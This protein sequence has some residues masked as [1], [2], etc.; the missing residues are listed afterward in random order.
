MHISKEEIQAKAEKLKNLVSLKNK[1]EDELLQIAE[2]IL[3]KGKSSMDI[4][5]LFS[6]RAESKR[7][8]ELLYKYL[9]DFTL[10]TVSDKN[11]LK[12]LIYLEILQQRLQE[13]LND[14]CK[15]SKK[16]VP[17]QLVETIHKNSDAILK[18]K[19]TL[20]LV[21]SKDKKESGLNVIET[22]MARFAQWRKN[23][24]ATRNLSCPHCGKMIMLKI[25]TEHWESQKHPYFRDRLLGNETLVRL[26]QAQRLTKKEVTDILESSTDYID[27]LINK[28]NMAPEMAE[29]T[30]SDVV[31]ESD[32]E[33][34]NLE[35]DVESGTIEAPSS[36][37]PEEE[38]KEHGSEENKGSRSADRKGAGGE[39]RR[40][41]SSESEGDSE[42]D[43]KSD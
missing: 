13:T 5:A 6:D 41:T 39:E 34:G 4:S 38:E 22:L 3:I 14:S 30:K 21:R 28:W 40:E 24:Q 2:D 16:G 7:A 33:S 10:S 23:N 26:Y 35:S 9:E 37:K 31:S 19:N 12:E 18:L 32:V 25:R 36:P 42:K 20:G 43:V 27:W 15:D 17:L 29:G 11:T 8:K 1:T